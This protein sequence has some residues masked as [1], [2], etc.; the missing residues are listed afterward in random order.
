LTAANRITILAHSL[1]G[2]AL[3]KASGADNS[4]INRMIFYGVDSLVS[5]PN[6]PT[7]DVELYYGE[8]DGLMSADKIDDLALFYSTPANIIPDLN[9]FCI[10]TDPEAG[11]RTLRDKDGKT[12]LT[13]E[14][15]LKTLL[16]AIFI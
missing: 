9:H 7:V 13:H 8:H 1:G 2:A 4:P 10:I 16:D 12:P 11:S 5:K 6:R 15:C 3:G 14:Q